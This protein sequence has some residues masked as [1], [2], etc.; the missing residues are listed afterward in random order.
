MKLEPPLH[1][2]EHKLTHYLL[3]QLERDDK[4]NY[5]SLAG[6]ELGTI[7]MRDVDEQITKFITL[8]PPN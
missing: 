4:S 2:D 8:Y 1:I 5:L 7:W 6:Y 3:V